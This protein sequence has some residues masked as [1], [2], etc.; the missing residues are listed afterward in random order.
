MQRGSTQLTLGTR[1]KNC[2]ANLTYGGNMRDK[3]SRLKD[4]VL[5]LGMAAFAFAADAIVDVESCDIVRCIG[6][7]CE[8][9]N[10]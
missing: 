7:T 6:G 3:V 8:R 1:T 4:C 9:R 5:L 10:G 2:Q